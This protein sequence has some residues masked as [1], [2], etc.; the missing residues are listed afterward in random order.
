[1]KI[2][3]KSGN[4]VLILSTPSEQVHQ[5][6]YL[7]L[8]DTSKKINI[9]AQIYEETYIDIP[10]LSEEI[11]RDEVIESTL[12]GIQ[13][14]S[15]E[16]ENI[17]MFIRDS[18]IL[19][20][21][22]RGMIKNSTLTYSNNSLPSR[23]YTKIKKISYNELF[24]IAKREG[25]R[26]IELGTGVSNEIFKIYAEALDGKL[27]I[28]T[29]KKESGKSHLSKLLA[30]NLAEL[31]API[32]IFDLNDEYKGL[33]K[34]K[35][36][37]TSNL[38]RKITRLVP[39]KSLKFNLQ[40]LELNCL[41]NI[42]THSLQLPGASLREFLRIFKLLKTKNSL[43]IDEL[44]NHIFNWKGNEFVRDALIS[45]FHTLQST[46]ILTDNNNSIKLEELLNT[47]PDGNIIIISLSEASP[48]LRRITVEIILSKLVNL[49]E[50]KDIKPVFLF[51]EEAHLY[52]R[53]TYWDDIITRMRHFGIFTTF[54]TNQPDA[55]DQGIYRQADNIFL[56]NFTNDADIELVSKASMVDADTVKS[57]V[58]TLP[59]KNCLVLGKTVNDLPVVVKI[60][61]SK[62]HAM[63]ETKLF[64]N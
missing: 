39:G 45:R 24:E 30:A 25:K 18:R 57:I 7:Q 16:I 53:D 58:R 9:L 29:G 46:G 8:E 44:R 4:E 64:F 19:K 48:L 26:E 59:S 56:F 33:T 43:N 20:C 12:E 3:G 35:N 32:I 62:W 15:L 5:G 36:G 27:N 21:K 40:Y 1:M 6:D 28:I 23:V 60:S 63:G 50:K 51:A 22:I 38:S 10:G 54:I 47:Q 37:T 14:E 2:L 31:G 42:L 55:I 61:E 13:G 11:L 49:L 34:N 17:S 41:C 52:L